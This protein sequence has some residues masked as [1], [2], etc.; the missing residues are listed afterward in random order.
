LSQ[1]R[2]LE[3]YQT[4][5]QQASFCELQMASIQLKKLIALLL[6]AILNTLIPAAGNTLLTAKR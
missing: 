4:L 3:R 2:I 6:T 5:T 1:I